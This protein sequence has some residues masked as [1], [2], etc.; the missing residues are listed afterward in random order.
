MRRL[1]ILLGALVAVA[2]VSLPAAA[3]APGSLDLVPKTVSTTSSPSDPSPSP[4][5]ASPP[6]GGVQQPVVPTSGGSTTATDAL[7]VVG[8]SVVAMVALVLLLR[9][10]LRSAGAEDED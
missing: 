8:F 4:T 3:V 7:T 1:S 5:S 2:A 9:A 6:P 10:G